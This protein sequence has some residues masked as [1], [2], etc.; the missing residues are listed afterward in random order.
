MINFI[1]KLYNNTQIKKY[2]FY[3]A[4]ACIPVLYIIN[5]IKWVNA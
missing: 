3:T 4:C 2:T 5:F 1:I